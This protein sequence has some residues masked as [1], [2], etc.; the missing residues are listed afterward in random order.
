MIAAGANRDNPAINDFFTGFISGAKEAN[1]DIKVSIAY[2]SVPGDAAVM[3]EIAASLYNS[4]VDVMFSVAGAAGL[5]IF[6]SAVDQGK[7]AV[8]V[9]S[10]QWLTY[11]NSESPELAEVIMTSMVKNIGGSLLTVFDEID[12]GTAKWGELQ[13]LG[14]AEGGVSLADNEN[15]RKL[16]PEEIRSTVSEY[17]QKIKSGEITVPSYYDFAEDQEFRD[18]VTSV[19]P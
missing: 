17:E 18:L 11:S 19:A 1:P 13:V 6:Q 2:N 4:G 3:G 12:A 9:D 14:I 5:G 16:V 10:D 15:Y 8:G 7:L